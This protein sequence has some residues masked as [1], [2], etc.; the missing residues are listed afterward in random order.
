MGLALTYMLVALSLLYS[1]ISGEYRGAPSSQSETAAR[2][3][4]VEAIDDLLTEVD[5]G[6]SSLR[7]AHCISCEMAEAVKG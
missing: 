1:T 3:M 7:T 6:L 2:S 5:A 4:S